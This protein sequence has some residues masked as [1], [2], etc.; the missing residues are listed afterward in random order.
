M[1]GA[2]DCVIGPSLTGGRTSTCVGSEVMCVTIHGPS[3][4][5]TQSEGSPNRASSE[6]RLERGLVMGT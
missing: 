1:G 3:P 5:S 6:H 4:D 2:L